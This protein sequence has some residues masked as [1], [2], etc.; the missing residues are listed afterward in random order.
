MR[1][2]REL[3]ERQIE[4]EREELRL[5][6]EFEQAELSRIYQAK[7]LTREEADL[8]AE[9]L[10]HDPEH[11]LDTKIR[12]ELGLD[13][14][15]LGSPMGAAWSSFVAFAIGAI[16]PLV[17]FLLTSGVTAIAI[18]VALALTSLFAVG[19]AVS[20]LTGRSLLFSGA[21]Q[22]AIGGVAALVTFLVGSL[23]PVDLG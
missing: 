22:V 6:P 7:G 21:R 2:Q 1:S 13:P 8:V 5:M 12:E 19:A 11:A 23:L 9:R 10:M 14:S 3:F 4:L 17:P 20:F 15:E 16:I 18:S